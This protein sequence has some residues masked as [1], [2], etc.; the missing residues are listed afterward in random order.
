[1]VLRLSLAASHTDP[2]NML[3]PKHGVS[4]CWIAS[5]NG[6]ANAIMTLHKHGADVNRARNDGLTPKR[7]AELK[8]NS[9]A[10]R[11]LRDCGM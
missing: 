11:A 1:M 6:H 10:V 9:A 2:R 3:L 4:P 5:S 8:G 7:I